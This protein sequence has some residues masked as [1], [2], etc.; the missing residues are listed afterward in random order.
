MLITTR[1]L[2]CF[3]EKVPAFHPVPHPERWDKVALHS[4]ISIGAVKE[5][6]DSEAKRLAIMTQPTKAKKLKVVESEPA[7][8][9]VTASDTQE[10]PEKMLCECGRDFATKRA[11]TIHKKRS[12]RS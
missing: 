9:E 12:H 1:P 5:V 11:L 2:I 6:S 10:S 8:A 7:P 3:G 4:C